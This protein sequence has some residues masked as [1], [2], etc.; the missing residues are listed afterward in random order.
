MTQFPPQV[1]PGGYQGGHMKPH[2]GVLILVFGILSFFICV[3]FGVASWVM[4]NGD[5]REMDAGLMDPSGRG[6]TQAGRILGMVSVGLTI[7]V[8]VVWV[9]IAG[10]AIIGGVA[11]G[12][13]AGP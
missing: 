5:L 2:R 9:L 7:L 12:S 3:L 4:G 8:I 13:G 1:N 10:L 6:L 11:A